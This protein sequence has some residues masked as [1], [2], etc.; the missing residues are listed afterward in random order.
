MVSFTEAFLL[1]AREG[2]AKIL[3]TLYLISSFLL[4]IIPI[5][6]LRFFSIIYIVL[7]YF[8]RHFGLSFSDRLIS[9]I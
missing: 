6:R 5:K 2:G 3:N 1:L 4:F 8:L 7:G 9:V